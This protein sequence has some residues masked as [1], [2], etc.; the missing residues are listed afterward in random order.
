MDS[1]LVE[2]GNRTLAIEG[3]GQAPQYINQLEEER[4]GFRKTYYLWI[5][6]F[7]I[8]TAT[9]SML[10]LVLASLSLFRLAPMVSV[11]PF[12][13]IN[14]SESENIVRNEAIAKDMASK[15]KLL[16][17]FIR[18]YVIIRN[19][20]INDPIEMR[21]RWMGGGMLNYLSSP[22][23]YNEFGRATKAIWETIFKQVLVR[24]VEII[25]ATR[26]GGNRSAVWKVDFKTYDLY[27][28]QS[29]TQAQQETTLRVRYWTA[30]ITAY[31]IPERGF[32]LPR[33][34]NPLG[35]TVTRFSQT[36]VEIF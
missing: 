32:V 17:M 13:L 2:N 34:V 8:L 36:E 26:Q 9:V 29:K 7:F 33:L 19:T 18:Q 1:K 11:E 6:R 30:S 5:S 28:E 35:F 31:F 25:S 12:L 23:V 4:S 27:N 10:F 22:E 15:D 24:E 21:T 16:E 14:Q 3:G 20:I